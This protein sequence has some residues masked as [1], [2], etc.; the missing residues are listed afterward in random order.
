MGMRAF[1]I[2]HACLE[3]SLIA[4]SSAAG[5]RSAAARISPAKRVL[6]FEIVV[7]R[8]SCIMYRVLATSRD[9]LK[10]GH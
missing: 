4:T 3:L 8:V 1:P 10:E 6:G 2:W 9:R 7:Y 5:L